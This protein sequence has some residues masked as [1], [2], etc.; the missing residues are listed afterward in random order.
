MRVKILFI[1][2]NDAIFKVMVTWSIEWH[3]QDLKELENLVEKQQ[4]RETKLF[5]M[6]LEE[7]QCK[8]QEV[9]TQW[10]EDKAVARA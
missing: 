10:R 7:R 6:K 2:M 8:E 1:A 9:A 4:K 5:L 3:T